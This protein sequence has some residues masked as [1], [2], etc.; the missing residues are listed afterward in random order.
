[1]K[2]RVRRS[3]ENKGKAK[4]TQTHWR[5]FQETTSCNPLQTDIKCTQAFFLTHSLKPEFLLE[6]DDIRGDIW[7]VFQPLQVAC[8][9][10]YNT[11]AP[12]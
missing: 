7:P 8:T 11:A 5:I 6:A 2:K 9:A 1:M 4:D 12:P 10:F 3:E